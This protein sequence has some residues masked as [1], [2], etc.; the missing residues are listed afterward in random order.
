[1]SGQKTKIDS[2]MAFFS[3]TVH[4]V[5]EWIIIISLALITGGTFYFVFMRYVMKKDFH[6][7]E[8]IVLIITFWLY[9][10][11][12]GYGS[13]KKVQIKAEVVDF[14]I[15]DERK[16]AVIKIVTLIIGAVVAAI[17][18]YWSYQMMAW[19]YARGTFTPYFK[20]SYVPAQIP[21]AIGYFMMAFYSLREAWEIKKSFSSAGSA[22]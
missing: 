5:E 20:I 22:K 9:F 15:K 13:Y 14:V 18:G 6:G 4:F 19:N 3:K 10:I 21:L 17:L 12:A 11:G 2:P 8:E 16:K 1:M 7:F